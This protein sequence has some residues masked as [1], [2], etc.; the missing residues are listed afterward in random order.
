[1]IKNRFRPLKDEREEQL[2]EFF[3]PKIPEFT[4]GLLFG[5]EPQLTAIS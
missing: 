4:T 5:P 1:M 2:G 3:K